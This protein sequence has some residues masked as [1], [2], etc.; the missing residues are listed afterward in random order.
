MEAAAR[1]PHLQKAPEKRDRLGTR[2]WAAQEV[3]KALQLRA[4]QKLE[5]KFEK[6]SSPCFGRASAVVV[7]SFFPQEYIDGQLS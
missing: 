6:F 1:N 2:L 3:G 4:L 7:G 5:A